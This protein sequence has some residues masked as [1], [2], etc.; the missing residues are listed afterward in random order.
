MRGRNANG[1][2]TRLEPYSKDD[3]SEMLTKYNITLFRASEY[4]C[5]YVANMCKADFLGSSIPDEEHLAKYIKDLIEDPDGYTGL[6]F[7]R[8]LADCIGSGVV[9]P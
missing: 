5:V 1:T 8:F 3:V 2:I 7:R 4:D 6:P 9:I